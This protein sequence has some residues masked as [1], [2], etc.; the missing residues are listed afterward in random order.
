MKNMPKNLNS[1]VAGLTAAVLLASPASACMP[2]FGPGE[3]AVILGA[4]ALAAAVPLLL[5]SAGL[6]AAVRAR[7]SGLTFGRG[8]VGLSALAF[9]GGVAKMLGA[10]SLPGILLGGLGALQVALFVMAFVHGP[11]ARP[12]PGR[13]TVLSEQ[14]LGL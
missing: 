6:V 8:V 1:A 5:M 9:E 3:V 10:G 2:S 13:V 11:E 7:R 4:L 14:A 12:L